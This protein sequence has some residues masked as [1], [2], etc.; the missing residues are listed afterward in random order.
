MGFEARQSPVM[1][2][3]VLVTLLFELA[4]VNFKSILCIVFTSYSLIV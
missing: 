1:C 2:I 3:L 4:K